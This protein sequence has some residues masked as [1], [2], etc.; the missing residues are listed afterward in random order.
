VEPNPPGLN[1]RF[2]VGVIYLQLIILS[3]VDDASVDS[4]MLFDQLR[5]SQDQDGTV[6]HMCSKG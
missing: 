5:E 3:V 4:E 1:P 6:F 2:G